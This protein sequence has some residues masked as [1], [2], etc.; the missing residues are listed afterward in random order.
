MKKNLHNSYAAKHKNIPISKPLTT[1]NKPKV[2]IKSSTISYKVKNNIKINNSNNFDLSQNKSKD[3][4]NKDDKLKKYK[5]IPIAYCGEDNYFNLVK[6]EKSKLTKYLNDNCESN[7]KLIGNERYKYAPSDKFLNDDKINILNDKI[8]LIP[9]PLRNVKRKSKIDELHNIQRNL[10]SL[11]RMQY[12]KMMR[13]KGDK[14]KFFEK[15]I[16]IQTWWK[17]LILKKNIIRIQRCYKLYKVRKKIRR[18]KTFQKILYKLIY[19][20]IFQKLRE[21]YYIIPLITKRYYISKIL[22]VSSSSIRKKII[23]IQKYYRRLKAYQLKNKLLYGFKYKLNNQKLFLIT[24]KFFKENELKQKQKIIII[25]NYIRLF[26]QKNQKTEK[27]YRIKKEIKGNYIEKI[28]L[29]NFTI[30][31]S[32]F[33]EKLKHVMQLIVFRKKRVNYNINSIIKIQR[34]YKFHYNRIHNDY[35]NIIKIKSNI[36]NYIAFIS[37]KRIRKNNKEIL[38]I[39]KTM[40]IFL[41]KI[42]KRNDIIRNKPKSIDFEIINKRNL[43]LQQNHIKNVQNTTLKNNIFKK[44]LYTNSDVVKLKNKSLKSDKKSINRINYFEPLKNIKNYNYNII[45]YISKKY[46]IIYISKV[47]QLQNRVRKYIYYKKAKN[48]YYSLVGINQIIK[49]NINRNSLISKISIKKKENIEKIELIQKYYKE[50]L[51]FIKEK[52]LKTPKKF[53]DLKASNESY[54]NFLSKIRI[55]SFSVQS[56]IKIKIAN[57]SFQGYL[58]PISINGFYYEKIIIDLNSYEKFKY[59]KGKIF[60]LLNKSNR[61][62]YISKINK[63]NNNKKVEII[64]K[65]IKMK[66]QELK[67]KENFSIIKKPLFEKYKIMK[68]HMDKKLKFKM[69]RNYNDFIGEKF[70][71]VYNKANLYHMSHMNIN[72]YYFISKTRKINDKNDL[73]SE[74][75]YESIKN[76][77]I[78]RRNHKGEESN[79]LFTDIESEI[80]T[81]NDKQKSL[82]IVP[83]ELTK[84][85]QINKNE[86][87]YIPNEEEN[88]NFDQ[89]DKGPPTFRQLD[90]E[91]EKSILKVINRICYIDKIRY[92]NKDILEQNSNSEKYLIC[93]ENIENNDLLNNINIKTQNNISRHETDL[94]NN[95]IESNNISNFGNKNSRYKYQMDKHNIRIFGE[96]T[97]INSTYPDFFLDR[98]KKSNINKTM[99][100]DKTRIK[101]Q[102]NHIINKINYF[103]NKKN[104]IYFFRLL[105]LFLTKNIQ[106]YIFYQ[107]KEINNKRFNKIF[108]ETNDQNFDFPFYIKA[109]YKLY[110]FCKQ[111]EKTNQKIINFIRDVFP[112]INK[113]KTVFYHLIYLSSQNKNKLINTNIYNISTEKNEL[114]E[115]LENFIYFDKN[116]TTKGLFKKIINEFTFKNTNIFTLIKFIDKNIENNMININS[117]SGINNNINLNYNNYSSLGSNDR[118]LD[119]QLNES[120]NQLKAKGINFEKK[121]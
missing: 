39:Q 67:L 17:K 43:I 34:A 108:E 63:K 36:R 104:Y 24:K 38:L 77:I 72:N 61:G 19:N 111:E 6:K 76:E 98:N 88:I 82:N 105:K 80:I 3:L 110:L 25:Q 103:K 118:F 79:F 119:S 78:K 90:K 99:S 92:K 13:N 115:F 42:R 84:N 102:N 35:R 109:L 69:K 107:I 22:L 9:I 113:R 7:I 121:D 91:E 20:K 32:N 8:G 87:N 16:F 5:D 11:R 97:S 10:V 26:L 51:K 75:E 12:D 49:S 14:N 89:E 64:Q 55:K 68:V 58:K 70:Y 4:T 74:K 33:I 114:I 116:I 71:T 94:L 81:I 73:N 54:L 85:I 93:N 46:I 45:S 37:I 29:I 106:E 66:K 112:F 30:K 83:L 27:Y 120:N 101:H 100:M 40:K 65:I 47:I 53:L 21:K 62:L 1:R 117:I 57:S 96:I 28:P 15:V 48:D 23:I 95:N 18:N 86:F 50:R 60:I 52:I 56:N 31:M 59:M 41:T 44:H 2:T